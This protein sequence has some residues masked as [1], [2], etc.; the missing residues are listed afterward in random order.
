MRKTK[1]KR[2]NRE[3][4]RPPPPGGAAA[5]SENAIFL[6]TRATALPRASYGAPARLAHPA[7]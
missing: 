7:F 1:K 3:L 2:K 6:A 4:A 5:R